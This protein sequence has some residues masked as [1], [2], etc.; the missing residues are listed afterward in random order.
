MSLWGGFVSLWGRFG[1]TS[2]WVWG[3]FG[4]GLGWVWEYALV[5]RDFVYEYTIIAAMRMGFK[6]FCILGNVFA[7][8]HAPLTLISPGSCVYIH[9]VTYL[10]AFSGFPHM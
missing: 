5:L 8:M 4:N 3:D 2:G 1:V 9:M 7:V 10:G 6:P